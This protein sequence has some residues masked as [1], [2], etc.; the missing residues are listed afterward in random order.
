[1]WN[2]K[3]NDTNELTYKTNRFTDLE[4]EPMVEVAGWEG[5]GEWREEIGR[6]GWTCTRCYIS[7][8]WP[9]GPTVY[10]RELCSMLRGSLDGRAVWGRM[11]TCVCMAESLHCSPG[12]ITFLISYVLCWVAQLCPTLCYLWTVAHQ[13]PLSMGILRARILEWVAMSS[14]RG[15]SQPRDQTHVSSVSCI[16]RWFFTTSAM[17][18]T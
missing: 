1:M 10:H 4:K 14:S 16:G 15:S 12:T 17:P 6:L 13:V 5:C 11:D 3:R 9:K 8:G 18:T 7:N 2:L